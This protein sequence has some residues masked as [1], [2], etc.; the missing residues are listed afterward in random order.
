MTNDRVILTYI[1]ELT[2]VVMRKVLH[3][4]SNYS[5]EYKMPLDAF[6]LIKQ[7]RIS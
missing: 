2:H 4:L 5:M 3:K 1:L 6:P 7:S